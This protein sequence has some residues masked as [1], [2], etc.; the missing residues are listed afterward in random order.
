MGTVLEYEA[1]FDAIKTTSI[2]SISKSNNS[3][4]ELNNEKNEKV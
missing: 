3:K 2:T 1:P 4:H